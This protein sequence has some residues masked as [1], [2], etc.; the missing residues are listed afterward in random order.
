MK[1]ELTTKGP[2]ELEVAPG[3]AQKTVMLVIHST[4]WIQSLH[5]FKKSSDEILT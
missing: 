1:R 2:F 3:T 5:V 4:T